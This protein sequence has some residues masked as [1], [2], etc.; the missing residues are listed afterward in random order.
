MGYLPGV[1]PWQPLSIHPFSHLTM[2]FAKCQVP[3][4]MLAGDAQQGTFCY[5]RQIVNDTRKNNNYLQQLCLTEIGCEPHV[6]LN[7]FQ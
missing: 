4:D 2:S 1:G 7:I 3:G 5:Q 6:Y